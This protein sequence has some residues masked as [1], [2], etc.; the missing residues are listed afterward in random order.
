MGTMTGGSASLVLGLILASTAAAAGEKTLVVAAGDCKSGELLTGMNAFGAAV[1]E[2]LKGDLLDPEL[3]L[4]Q[5]RPRPAR[6]LE[7]IKR[8]VEQAR[9]LYY[10]SQ[11]DK[12]REQLKAALADLD[13]VSP[14]LKPWPTTADTLVLL[15]MVEKDL[16]HKPETA[17]AFRRVVRVDPGYAL[18]VNLVPPSTMQ[19]FEGLRRELAKAKRAVLQV[20]ATA[21]AT[22]FL[23]G[24]P[25]GQTPLRRDTLPGSYTLVLVRGD[26]VSFT[27]TV[28]VEK[29]TAVQVELPLE[30][31][32][33]TG[34][35]LCLSGRPDAGL[36]VKLGTAAG[37]ERVL[38]FTLESLRGDPPN[39]QA[40]LYVAGRRE[41]MASIVPPRR[42][43]QA[44]AHLAGFITTGEEM[45]GIEAL[46][47]ATHAAPAEAGAP[48][49]KATP[50]APAPPP[51][52]AVQRHGVSLARKVSVGLLIG[53][54]AVAATGLV[55]YLAGGTN[56]DALAGL[57]QAN[58]KLPDPASPDHRRALDLM[59]VIDANRNASFALLGVGAGAALSGLVG[60][61]L[62]PADAPVTVAVAPAPAGGF[63]QVS[64]RF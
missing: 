63:V 10:G 47:G 36:A 24:A 2:R 20:Q 8:Q 12:A 57:I 17:E 41:R 18:D 54:A 42:D 51:A 21:G 48:P 38:V 31:A 15:A 60:F 9:T 39:Y 3:L 29:D 4:S 44:L 5:L 64:G 7:D 35:P 37:A 50:E 46:E 14:Q 59:P 26:E 11:Y 40:A 19:Y 32:L 30:G 16:G 25:V 53:G 52:E 49:A 22:V 23:D 34:L 27:R 6:S 43:S 62:F 28:K 33:G 58:G 45:P 55:V 13:K 1:E 56:R 61:L